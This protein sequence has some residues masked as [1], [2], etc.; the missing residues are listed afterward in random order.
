MPAVPGNH[1]E[2]YARQVRVVAPVGMSRVIYEKRGATALLTLN[3][4]DKLN[5]I[6]V[7]M[8]E[9]LVAALEAAEKDTD[10]RAIVLNGAGRAFSAG[11]DLDMGKRADGET[12][13]QF[14]TRALRKDFATIMRVRD[15]PKPV[16]AAVHG[17][18]LGSSME[19][20]ALCDITIA[21]E[22]C[23]FGA[24]EVRYGSGIVCMILP[25][26]VGEKNA[27]ELLLV[28]SDRIDAARALSMGL[29]NHVVPADRLLQQALSM[30]GE[31]AL[32]DPLA[33]QLTK[34][35]IN[36]RADAAGMRDALR[37]ALEIDIEIESTETAESKEFN[38]ILQAEGPKAALR[39][40]AAQLPADQD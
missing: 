21:A 5:A 35:A 3:R 20:A 25:W 33:V 16:I 24:P 9:E 28:G 36:V 31:I 22:A 14:M 4:P 17:Y 8:Q 27:R 1:P 38:R 29:V 7:A 18:C 13:R 11:F 40:R 39:W 12:T 34:K 26:I 32:N 19:I 30:A 2:S 23:R 10:I 15:C 6:D 37:Q